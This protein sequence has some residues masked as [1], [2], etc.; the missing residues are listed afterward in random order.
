MDK[1]TGIHDMGGTE[2]WGPAP[3]PRPD[4][5][6]FAERWQARAFALA[7][8]SMRLSGTNLNAF[9]HAMNRLDRRDYLDD[10]YYGRWLHG[11]ENL[12]LDSSIIAPGTVEA[13][14]ANLSGASAEEPAPPE[15]NRPDYA[16]AAAGSLREVSSEPRFAVGSAV[17]AR[18]FD[19]PGHTRLPR[20][21][22]GHTGAVVIVQPA[23]VLPDTNA[24]FQGENP[25]WVYTVR[26]ASAELFG[27]AAEPFALNVDLCEDYLE[28][29]P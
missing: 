3:V 11:A 20:Y 29:A 5:P 23:Q 28:E 16:P 17:R 7:L 13:R 10:G 15:P 2:G 21:V 1:A 12:L 26:F 6:V 14:A 25:Q 19:P 18:T 4:E 9:R 8:L 22:M 24:H 27:P